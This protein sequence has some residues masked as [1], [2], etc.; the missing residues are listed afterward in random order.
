M[1]MLLLLCFALSTLVL[2]SRELFGPSALLRNACALFQVKHYNPD[3]EVAASGKA[4][5]VLYKVF[6]SA[7]GEFGLG[8]DNLASCTTA[9]SESAVEFLCVE[10]LSPLGVEWDR[11]ASHQTAKACEQAFGLSQHPTSIK[12]TAAC[13]ILRL[14]LEVVERLKQ[15][16]AIREFSKGLQVISFL[17]LDYK[18]PTVRGRGRVAVPSPHQ[19]LLD[20]QGRGMESIF[21]A[22]YTVMAYFKFDVLRSE[23]HTEKRKAD[24]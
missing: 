7:L 21:A 18:V 1:T 4:S 6:V 19:L 9:S 10:H 23:D 16:P 5:E 13:D 12:S 8:I 3:S 2:T 20:P 15:P 11:C 22:F 14:A 17:L 24:I